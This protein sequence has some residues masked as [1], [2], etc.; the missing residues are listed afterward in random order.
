MALM[1]SSIEAQPRCRTTSSASEREAGADQHE[2]RDP[3]LV[4]ER[5]PQGDGPPEGIADEHGGQLRGDAVD[6]RMEVARFLPHTDLAVRAR[7]FADDRLEVLHFFA[8]A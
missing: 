3:I 7:P 1:S 8:R 5:G 6:D 2:L 4:G